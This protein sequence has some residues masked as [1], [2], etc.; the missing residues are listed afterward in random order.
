MTTDNMLEFIKECRVKKPPLLQ[1]YV[2]ALYH[3]AQYI[4]E[5]NI[6]A[7]RPHA[8]WGTSSPIKEPQ[9]ALIEKVF[10]APYYDQYGSC[11][12]TWISAQCEK[13]EGLHINHEGRFVE[14][15]DDN[16][17][18]K[19]TGETGKILITDLDNYAFPLIRY[20][21]GD[22][23]R[24]IDSPCSCG[25]ALPLMDKVQGRIS[26]NV[27][28]PN[29]T[30]LS[31]EYLTTIFDDYAEQINQFQVKQEEDYSLHIYYVP[32]TAAYGDINIEKKLR[33]VFKEKTQ[34]TVPVHFHSVNSIADD[35]GK[36]RFIISKVNNN[37]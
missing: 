25:R 24:R 6:D 28:L 35:R 7:W 37:A 1:G 12:V 17:N 30:V 32:N 33:N 5:N 27:Y 26:E 20:E 15:V 3:L 31:G 19:P 2:G 34:Q 14:F 18:E 23:G 36:L 13:Q 9:R 16:N 22:L 21:N 8:I 4:D 29:G 11:E 10:K